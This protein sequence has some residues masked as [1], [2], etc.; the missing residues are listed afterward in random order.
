MNDK[1]VCAN[2]YVRLKPNLNYRGSN[3]SELAAPIAQKQ[4]GVSGFGVASLALGIISIP[5][6]WIPILGLLS[7]PTTLIG[8][9]LGLVGII[10]SVVGKRSSLSLSIVGIIVCALGLVLAL[11]STGAVIV[12]PA[13]SRAAAANAAVPP[14]LPATPPAPV[15]SVQPSAPS[16]TPLNQTASIGDISVKIN[17][18]LVG[19]VP[20]A[21]LGETTQSKDDL[22]II[23]LTLN[24][25]S[26]TK[27]TS[28]RTWNGKDF[29][30]GSPDFAILQDDLGNSYKRID[31]G[32]GSKIVGVQ[33]ETRTCFKTL[34]NINSRD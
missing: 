20:I 10:V 5:I 19:K 12:A 6:A 34:S 33:E 8:G 27:K 9:A 1:I 15:T 4:R 11:S 23:K 21:H 32:F 24:N 18:V 16:W 14:S 22:L 3:N 28:F 29:N 13:M 26:S 17:S 7:I 2:C 31:F 25:L 30:L